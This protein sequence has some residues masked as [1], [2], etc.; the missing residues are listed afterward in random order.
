VYSDV[1]PLDCGA[2]PPLLFLKRKNK[3]G[4]KAPQS[5][6]KTTKK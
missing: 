6:G 1:F 3:S 4:G 2:F 5:K